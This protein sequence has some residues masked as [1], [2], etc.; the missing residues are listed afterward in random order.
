MSE[1]QANAQMVKVTIN[2]PETINKEQQHKNNNN[3]K[4]SKS[5][6][7]DSLIFNFDKNAKIN[8]IFNILSFPISTRFLTNFNLFYKKNNTNVERDNTELTL[9]QLIDDDSSSAITLDLVLKP[10]T[11]TDALKHIINVRD[12]IGFS[13]ETIDALSDFSISTGSKFGSMPFTEIK[14]DDKSSLINDD[15]KNKK[16]FKI[17]DDEKEK[18]ITVTKEI[19]ELT[20]K[21][22]MNNVMSTET[23]IVNPCLRSLSLSA[24]NPVPAFYKTKGHLLYLQVITLEGETFHITATPS[25]FFVNNSTVNKFDPS[26]KQIEYPFT[27][28]TF[29]DLLINISKKFSSHVQNLD[30]KLSNLN[31]IQYVKPITTFLNK[32]WLI[33]NI[34]NNSPD[35][36]NLQI[37]SLPIISNQERNFNSEFQTILELPKNSIEQRLEYENLSNKIIHEFTKTSINDSMDIFYNNLTPMNPDDPIEKHIF[38]K[39]NIFYSFVTDINLDFKDKGGKDAAFANANQDLIT[40]NL[41]NRL[42][43]KNVHHLLTTIIDFSGKRILAQTPIPG[44][45]SPIGLKTVNDPVTNEE[46][47]EDLPTDITVKHGFDDNKK[48]LVFDNDFDNIISNE[49][50]KIFHL[51]T[52][53]FNNNKISFSTLTKGIKGS[54]KRDYIMELANTY[55]LDI[56]FINQNFDN[57]DDVENRYPHRQTLLRPSLVEK[58]WNNKLKENDTKIEEAFNDNLFSYNPDAYQINSNIEDE[59]VKDMSTYLN[60]TV[61]PEVLNNFISG[62]ISIPYNGEH[63]INTLHKEGINIRYLGKFASLAKEELN[64]QNSVHEKKLAEIQIGNKEYEEWESEYLIKIQNLIIERQKKVNEY[65]QQG[66]PVPKELTEELKLDDDEIR[67][68]VKEEPIIVKTDELLPLINISELEIFSRSL[69]HVLRDLSST[70]PIEIVPSMV[71]YVLNLLLGYRYN[72]SPKAEKVDSFFDIE[73]F[74]FTKL[75]RDDLLNKIIKE[76]KLR[77]RYDLPL[78]WIEKYDN[79]PYILLRSISKKF[80]IQLINKDYYFTKESYEDF[81]NSQDK[82]IKNKLVTPITTFSFNDLT[83]IPIV[84]GMQH[85]SSL[86]E[87]YMSEG[88]ATLQK[89][90]KLGLTLLSQSIAIS[91]EVYT[92]LHNNVADKYLELSTIYS[93]LGLIP[94]AIAF[95]RKACMIYE[96]V[97]GVD[98]FELLRAMSNLAFLET[99]NNSPFNAALIYKRL[100]ETFKAFNTSNLHDAGVANALN[101][102]EQLSLGVEDPKL[103]IDILHRLSELVIEF[104]GEDSLAYATVES[105]IGNLYATQKD[106]LKSYNHLAVTRKIFTS[107]LGINH[108]TTVQSRQWVEGLNNILQ[109]KRNKKNLEG[110]QNSAGNGNTTKSK[111]SHKS[112]TA[113]PNDALVD[114]SVDE[115]LQ[116]IEGGDGKPS[117][118]KSKKKKHGSK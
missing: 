15:T 82:K 109:E 95:C 57:V 8:S 94:E 103:T 113:P 112:K 29:Y 6:K 98:S 105:K 30:K 20:K 56:N 36:M 104:E 14:E 23:N 101:T 89:D 7:D 71:A 32:P 102:L 28:F 61:I 88:I 31:S 49:F 58:W 25:G 40:I 66:K 60:D 96:R 18:F 108:I 87:E 5:N 70:L 27:K 100:V 116:F 72:E 2:L 51:K 64:K 79:S 35:L 69:K 111:K 67:K 9:K 11:T 68:P 99:T 24:Y 76:S 12:F 117:D 33:S 53:S 19:L 38:L 48:T 78:N 55:P 42:N 4:N 90:Q 59:N 85:F 34:P 1:Q 16:L 47:V 75:T 74:E 92:I 110:A 50:S 114:K 41:L 97:T 17:T 13:N 73:S 3:K 46:I 26:I 37:N 44:L 65:I 83:I 77:F 52:Q 86:C 106:Y 91:E 84:K 107:Q 63:L 39:N 54:D 62:N 43:I 80:G 81:V 93:K 45:L 115:L 10:Y 21:S 118:K 22:S